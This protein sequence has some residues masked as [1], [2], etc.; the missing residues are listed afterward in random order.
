MNVLS[1]SFYEEK[2]LFLELRG[3]LMFMM[4]LFC[5][6]NSSFLFRIYSE[7]LITVK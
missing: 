1:V 2:V 4:L 6:S 7:S 5:F 3:K